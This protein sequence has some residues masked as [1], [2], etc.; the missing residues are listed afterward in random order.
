MQDSALCTLCPRNCSVDRRSKTGYCSAPLHV[1]L[2]RAALHHWEE[3]CISGTRGSGAVFFCGCPLKC[4]YCQN[5][6][7]SRLEEGAH[8][9]R[10][11]IK[12]LKEIY[13]E[14]I[15]KGAHNINLVTPTH[16]AH[17]VLASLDD[18]LPV[19]VV[20]NCSGYE[21][22]ETLRMLKGK[23][24]IYMPDLKYLSSDIAKR[25]SFAPDYPDIAKKAID[26]MYEQVG[27]PVF[28][29]EGIMRSGVIIRHLILPGQVENTLDFIDYISEHFKPGSVL[30]HIMAQYTPCGKAADYPEINRKI[31]QEE[32]DRVLSYLK[33]SSIED[34]YIQEMEAAGEEYIPDFDG[35]GVI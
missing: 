10:V 7:I 11:S 9:Q 25:Y 14:L 8:A 32:Y 24:Q 16:Y 23:I 20:Y 1:M 19:P 3:P 21:K 29:E 17:A 13:K 31:T 12:R 27:D 18:P 22:I 15:E 35:T 6:G 4:V 33:Y 30:I 5:F 26:E 2:A 28:D 34:G